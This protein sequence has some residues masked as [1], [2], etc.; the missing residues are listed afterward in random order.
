MQTPKEQ[1]V[2]L[3]NKYDQLI[4]DNNI[5]TAKQLSQLTYT[6]REAGEDIPYL[7]VGTT[8]VNYTPKPTS[9]QKN[10][11]WFNGQDFGE[12]FIG[13]WVHVLPNGL[14]IEAYQM[15]AKLAAG[16]RRIRI[17]LYDKTYTF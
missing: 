11:K 7:A 6:L 3:C 12:W 14:R 15:G 8:N 4:A 13:C 9:K 5:T 10:W 2:A 17:P 1:I 16:S